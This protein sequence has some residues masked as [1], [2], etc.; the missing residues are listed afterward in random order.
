MIPK[1]HTALFWMKRQS[2]CTKQASNCSK[3]NVSVS[4]GL[5]DNTVIIFYLYA[6][7]FTTLLG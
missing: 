4:A 1:G 7:Q 3:Y 2:D 5:K 6:I